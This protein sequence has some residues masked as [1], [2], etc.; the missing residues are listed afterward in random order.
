MLHDQIR[1]ILSIDL[2]DLEQVTRGEINIVAVK[3]QQQT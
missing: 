1:F 3:C 2:D